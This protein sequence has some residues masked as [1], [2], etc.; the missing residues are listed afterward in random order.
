MKS[1]AFI[2][3]GGAIGVAQAGLFSETEV[4]NTLAL[5][6]GLGSFSSPGGSVLIDGNVG[7]NDVDWFSFTLTQTSSLSIFA[8][9]SANNGDGIMQVV[10]AGGDVIAF[11]DDSGV[12]F[13][14]ALQLTSLAAG[15]YYV[16]L[17]GFGDA[18]ASS[19]GTDTLMDGIGH[20]EA[21]SYKL[22]VGFTVI[23]APSAL[24]LVGLG[25]LVATRRR[26]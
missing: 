21:F 18:D 1:V 6:N 4:N 16:G 22:T 14:P 20:T 7:S 23:P 25:G 19:V 2:V 15:T 26:R 13:M 17:S 10:A 3:L 12:G 5:A 8:A 9:F 11:D 24:A